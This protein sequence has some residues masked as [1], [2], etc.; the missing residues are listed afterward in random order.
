MIKDVLFVIMVLS[1]TVYAHTHKHTIINF[2]EVS[3][4]EE[5]RQALSQKELLAKGYK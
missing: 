5:P 2:I 1:F 3:E 4:G